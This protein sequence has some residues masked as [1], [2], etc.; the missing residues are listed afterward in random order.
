MHNLKE[1]LKAIR[2]FKKGSMTRYIELYFEAKLERLFK[3][4]DLRRQS[5][6]AETECEW[7]SRS[8]RADIHTN[9]SADG[10][11]SEPDVVRQERIKVPTFDETYSAWI[12]FR[13]LFNSLIHDNEM[14]PRVQKLQYLRA[15]VQ[16]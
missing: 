1:L 10:T 13:D 5:P 16:A 11:L 12:S 7:K 15:S 3:M 9:G 8:S 2:N 6:A 4:E 14:L